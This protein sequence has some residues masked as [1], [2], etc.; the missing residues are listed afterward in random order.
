MSILLDIWRAL[1]MSFAMFWEIYWALAL[2]FGLSAVV[3]AVVSKGEM[4]RLLPD[5]SLRSL[6]RAALLGAASS[7]C[8]YAAVAITRSMVRK[9]A[10]FT[11]AIAFEFASTNL[12]V[13]LGIILWLLIGWQFTLAEYIGG[14]VMILILAL[15][16]K[17]CLK[18]SLVEEATAQANK[19]VAGKME[20]HAAHDMSVAGE[21]TLLH[22][23]VSNEGLTAI[24]HYFVMDISMLWKEIAAGL[25]IT[26]ALAAW[27]PHTFWQHFFLAGHT[28]FLPMLWGALVGPLVAI[29][30]FVCS[31]GNV[32]LAAILWNGGISFSGVISFIFADLLILP[33]LSI[34]QKYYGL[35]MAL[36]LAA[37]SYV[38]MVLAGLAIEG[39]FS[40]F[41][42]IPT[43]RHSLVL[44][45][46]ITLNYTSVL[47]AVFGVLS[48]C[49]VARF[50]KTGGPD[51]MV[52][53]NGSQGMHSDHG[54]CHDAEHAES[55]EHSH[56]MHQ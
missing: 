20:G 2:G 14:M 48:A 7:S 35:K 17:L 52:M 51:M 23:M 24:S 39:L 21:G 40:L 19:G 28:G 34:Y 27:V 4:S 16:F 36:F 8:S 41:H 13:E 55:E 46:H 15:L 54:H 45:P 38:A 26:G 6:W 32:P 30:S 49:L 44:D 42:L 56:P 50:L 37:A 11:A 25:L 31:I 9:G 5:S 33:I 1:G 12:V 3:Q 18:A 43:A 53:M 10:N 22:R 47:N 29:A